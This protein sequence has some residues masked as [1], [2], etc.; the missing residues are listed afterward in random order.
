MPDEA[1][2]LSFPKIHSCLASNANGLFKAFVFLMKN[3]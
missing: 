1:D 3:A 2:C